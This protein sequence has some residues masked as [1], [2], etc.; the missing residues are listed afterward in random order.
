MEPEEYD[1][2]DCLEDRMWWFGA[3]HRNLLVLA[4]RVPLQ[5]ASLPI[6]DAGC[7][8]GGFLVAL[9]EKYRDKA[10]FGL[11]ADLR[12]CSRA[13][14]KSRRPICAASVNDLPFPDNS[15]A[16]IFTADV[17]C[18]EGVDENRALQQFHRC[19]A[20]GGYLIVNL[21]AYRWLLS[22]HDVAVHN[23]RR[24]TG[25]GLCR[26]LRSAGFR[27]IYVSYW[28]AVLLPLMATARKLLPGDPGEG[29]DVRPYPAAIEA[30]GRAATWFETA[31]LGRGL[32]LPFGG[33]VLAI[34]AKRG[35]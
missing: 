15:I 20:E 11:D 30:L 23:V 7:G 6:L 14:V 16:A 9:A 29:S 8:T 28:N 12:A 10:L 25:S 4:S 33:S 19:L 21:P 5:V 22:R 13:A 31:L 32:R 17:L 24:Y 35:A 1:K 34:A 2:L 18:H 26:L 27:P 3:L